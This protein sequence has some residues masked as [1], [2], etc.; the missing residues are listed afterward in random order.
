MKVVGH[1][2]YGGGFN[3]SM[4]RYP[5]QNFSVMCLC[6]ADPDS[7][8]GPD[9][10]VLTAQVADIFLTDQFKKGAGGVN[11]TVADA[12]AIISIPEK[13]LASLNGL[14]FDPITV[15]SSI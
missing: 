3:S 1:G 12:P 7:P 13:E 14:Y 2:G 15:H 4:Y 10:W 5:E 8:G 6:N 11:E 9:S